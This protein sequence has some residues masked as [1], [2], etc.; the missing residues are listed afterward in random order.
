MPDFSALLNLDEFESAAAARLPQMVFDY[1]AGGAGDEVTL[2][3]ARRA[4]DDISIRYRVLCDV[5]GRSLTVS[6][7]GHDF[8]SPL[9]VAPMAFQRLA[10][11]DG[12][13][14]TARAAHAAGAGM[15]LSTLATTSIEEVRSA[16][17]APLWFQLYIYRDRGLSRALVE[18]AERAGCSALV[19]TVDSP[20][21]GRRERD[22][23]TGFHVPVDIPVPN[24]SADTRET[25]AG[26]GGIVGASALA[27]FVTE[28][29]DSSISWRDLAWLRSITT[30]PILVK[31]I[32]RGDDARLALEHGASGV[33][34]SNHG[35]RQL[36]TAIPTARALPEVA[37]AMR[38]GGA[39]LVDGGIRRGTDVLK[40]L[41]LGA[42]AVLVGRPVL[43][44]LALGGEAGVRRVLELLRDEC[45]LALA[46]AGCRAPA[47]VTRDFV[48]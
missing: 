12:E 25:L 42:Q 34:V 21:L 23:R 39:L 14:A 18:R 15:I 3:A 9:I 19:L 26:L 35:G 1:F 5:S 44:G 7:L 22:A 8:A 38:G 29:W 6:M 48:V 11:A 2:R 37:D 17:Q 36:D 20:L 24:L 46:L 28:F 16:T 13:V 27:K 30:V 41:A 43:W 40:A 4:W 10:H 45:A 33:I 32:V 31:G 47:E